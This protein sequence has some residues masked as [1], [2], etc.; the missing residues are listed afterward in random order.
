MTY[1]Q[2]QQQPPFPPPPRKSAIPLSQLPS[3]KSL[4]NLGGKGW[5]RICDNDIAIVS[6]PSSSVITSITSAFY[7]N[8]PGSDPSC[9]NNN[10]LPCIY[11][12]LTQTLSHRLVGLNNA[13]LVVRGEIL[14]GGQPGWLNDPCPGV[15]K[16]F[17]VTWCCGSPAIASTFPPFDIPPPPLPLPPPVPIDSPP[18]LVGPPLPPADFPPLPINPCDTP[19]P[20]PKGVYY[21]CSLVGQNDTNGN[22]NQGGCRP[23][24]KGPFPWGNQS[25]ECAEQCIRVS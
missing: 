17:N 20:C 23:G 7:G 2:Q 24:V 4:G 19:T 8:M 5:T 6:C 15:G 10:T 1:G 18:P 14:I 22:G 12:N 9:Q 25:F 11:S 3:C 21:Y 16:S 13:T